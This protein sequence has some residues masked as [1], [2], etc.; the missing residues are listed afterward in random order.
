MAA[1][2]T[3]GAAQ[4]GGQ[5]GGYSPLL[6]RLPWARVAL[7]PLEDSDLDAV[8]RWQNDPGLRDLTMGFRLPLPR[9]A[10]RD[11]IDGLRSPA[12]QSARVVYAIRHQG[13]AAGIVQLYGMTPGQRRADLGVFLDPGHRQQGLGVAA[14]GLALDFGFSGLDLRRVTA[15]TLATN[16]G[17]IRACEALGFRHEGCRRQ[18]YFADGHARDVLIYGLLAAEFVLRPMPAGALRLC[19]S[20]P[21]P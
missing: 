1:G 19:R 5:A 8:H 12:A 20:M 14:M 15:E 13:A 11:W 2:D 3:Q 21:A 7:T 4:P 17:M 6:Q 18:E 9:A 10:V 16:R